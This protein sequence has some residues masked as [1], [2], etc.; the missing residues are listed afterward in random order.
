LDYSG[1][2][3]TANLSVGTFVSGGTFGEAVELTSNSDS[4][5]QLGGNYAFAGARSLCT[6]VS[7]T[8]STSGLG[9]P[10]FSGGT[11]GAGDFYS[12]VSDMSTTCTGFPAGHLFTDHWGGPGCEPSSGSA[13]VSNSAWSYV[14][15]E[16]DGTNTTVF[17]N[18]SYDYYPVA[19]YN[20]DI[21]TVTVS[22]QLM[23]GTSTQYVRLGAVD[24][25]SLW[26]RALSLAEMNALYNAGGGCKVH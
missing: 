19:P 16:W 18:G 21:S 10:V 22:S 25:V 6:W 3:Y 1:N 20:W 13:G 4:W 23:G 2:G 14:C 11:S 5:I 12:Y 24:E 7:P 17:A 26:D 8:P 9:L 15:Y